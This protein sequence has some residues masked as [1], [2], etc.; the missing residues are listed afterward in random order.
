MAIKLPSNVVK[1]SNGS[2]AYEK[3]ADYYRQYSAEVLKKNIGSYDT[4]VSFAEKEAKMNEAFFGEIERVAG[5]KRPEN[6]PNEIWASNPNF[7]WATFAV[8][9]MMI[10][11]ILPATIVDSIGLYTDIRNVGFGDVPLFKIPPRSLMTVSTGSNAQRQTL[12]QKQYKSD[13]TVAVYNHVITTS[14]DMYAVLSGRQSLAEAARVAVLSVETDMS[15]EAYSAVLAGLTGVSRPAALKVEGA[16]DMAKLVK[17]CQIVGAYNFNMKPIIA[18]TTLALMKVIPDSALG[19]RLNTDTNNMSINVIQNVYGYDFMTL[20][21]VATGDYTNYTTVLNDETLFIL[22]PAADKLVKMVTEGAT[23]SNSN[24]YY[25]N[26]DLT[27][28]YTI[29]KRYGA[30]FL[31]G[32]VA[33]SYTINQ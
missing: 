1:F 31:S 15:K 24:D 30:E 28:N 12:I 8:I 9:T 14:V 32:S 33:A 3:F 11:T 19:F 4:S 16:F 2:T 23:L 18:G 29:N 6:V 22:S 5:F 20:P 27:S 7:K 21:Q 26:A 25:D 17:L 13:A 10:E